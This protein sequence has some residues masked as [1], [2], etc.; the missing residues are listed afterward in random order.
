MGKHDKYIQEYETLLQENPNLSFKAYCARRGLNYYSAHN[1]FYRKHKKDNKYTIRYASGKVHLPF[2]NSLTGRIILEYLKHGRALIGVSSKDANMYFSLLE[3]TMKTREIIDDVLFWDLYRT[4]WG[5]KDLYPTALY[6]LHKTFSYFT[7]EFGI[8]NIFKDPLL[9]NHFHEHSFWSFIRNNYCEDPSLIAV[10][11]YCAKEKTRLSWIYLAIRNAQL[12]AIYISFI[13]ENSCDD[14]LHQAKIISPFFEPSLSQVLTQTKQ[15]R[16]S[17]ESFWTQIHFFE[18]ERFSSTFRHLAIVH[19]VHFYIFYF[20]YSLQNGGAMELKTITPSLLHSLPFCRLIENGYTVL[21]FCAAQRSKE[22]LTKTIITIPDLPDLTPRLNNRDFIITDWTI[23]NNPFF[24]TIVI[25]YCLSNKRTFVSIRNFLDG[26]ADCLNYLTRNKKERIDIISIEDSRTL[27]SYIINTANSASRANTLLSLLKCLIR[28]AEE[29]K[30]VQVESPMSYEFFAFLYIENKTAPAAIP[31][32]HAT[33]IAQALYD[34]GKTSPAYR[35]YFVLLVLLIETEFRPSQLCSVQIN[36][37]RIVQNRDAYILQGISKMSK[38]DIESAAISKYTYDLL[39]Q[40]LNDTQELRECCSEERKQNYLFLYPP[41]AKSRKQGCR[42]ITTARFSEIVGEICKQSNLPHYSAQNFRDA[43][44]TFSHKYDIA[45]KGDG[46]YLR[47]LSGHK[48][49]LTTKEHY[50][51]KTFNVLSGVPDGFSIGT[52]EE[53]QELESR[54]VSKSSLNPRNPSHKTIDGIGFCPE[55]QC[56]FKTMINCV[57]CPHIWY[58][59]EQDEKPLRVMLQEIEEILST[60]LTSHER[61]H[62]IQIKD[63]LQKR[64]VAISNYLS[65]K[66]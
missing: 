35:H 26:L 63:A 64:L 40:T 51:D 5:E 23:I 37:F 45:N 32:E 61:E 6:L 52:E 1:A 62:K 50:V 31:I 54:I 18:K 13:Q 11:N 43:H 66:K 41:A 30:R 21:S 22:C 33:L 4:L 55:S 49:E 48:T 14:L 42:I 28:W 46:F 8:K 24:R 12:R 34:R 39:L 56:T 60:D 19:I 3:R 7:K 57:L 38:G 17:E 10:F 59:A 47:I 29:N 36:R 16:L 2:D 15:L 58:I 44:M 53:L 27:R 25:D 65:I 9:I 20:D